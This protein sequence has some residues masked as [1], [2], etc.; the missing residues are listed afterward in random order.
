MGRVA[1][2]KKVKKSLTAGAGGSAGQGR[3]G[4]SDYFDTVGVWGFG[5]NGRKARKRSRTS[6]KLRAD[7]KKK[8]EN[9]NAADF[10]VAPDGDDFDIDDLVGSLKREPN[11]NSLNSAAD[12]L[13]L[14]TAKRIAPEPMQS[15]A[16][17]PAAL[18]T[19]IVA[20]DADQE[21]LLKKFERQVEPPNPVLG[22]EGRMAGESKRAYNKR[23]KLETRQIIQRVNKQAHNPEKREKKKLFLNHKKR[24]SRHSLNTARSDTDSA[25]RDEDVQGKLLTGEQAVAARARETQVQ[26]GEQADRPPTFK[27]LPRGAKKLK[28]TSA[29]KKQKLS[30]SNPAEMEAEH[31]AMEL[32]R[33][34]VQAQYA[35]VKARRRLNGDFHL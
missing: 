18:P 16:L 15:P 20:I 11:P 24:K 29:M 7:R 30:L 13:T 26:F 8:G 12:S 2:Y 19:D 27:Q 9:S 23:V 4:T 35:A 22:A 32:M 25:D 28:T 21:K 31:H 33:R 3:F 34:R 14:A 10:D 1:R 6:L 5:E 17:L